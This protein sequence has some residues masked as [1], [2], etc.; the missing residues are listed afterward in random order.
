[1]TR[2]LRWNAHL[3]YA[4]RKGYR[5]VRL[6]VPRRVWLAIVIPVFLLSVGSVGYRWIEG[7]PWTYFDG[8]YMTAITITTIGYGETHPLSNAGRLFTVVLAYSGIF[9]LAYFASE[10][11]RSV[12][13][14]ELR[15]VI[16]RQW[17]DEQLASLGGHLIVCGYGRMGKIV[18]SELE[19]QKRRFVLVERSAEAL[20]DAAY[21]YGLPLVGD[22]TNDELLRKAGVDRAKALVTVVGSDA[23][24]LYITLSA[25]LLNP[26]LLIVARA[27][28]EDA[29]TKLR[30]VGANKVISPYLAGAH[31]AVQAVLRPAVLHFMEMAT[32]P[33]FLDLQIE[34]VRVATGSALAG[35]SLGQ[36]QIHR[37]LGVVVV[38]V[39]RPNGELL[40]NPPS[41]VVIEA[42]AVLIA[43]GQRRHLDRLEKLATCEPG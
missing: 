8:F 43:L 26:K 29:E 30:K 23:D 25:R 35:R 40:Y 19:R 41:D 27:E 6:R 33:E 28:E 2:W 38:G 17:V 14:G 3:R 11:V 20:K 24:N 15:Q 36:S 18:C 9:T 16:G 32:R 42:E 39:V 13:T 22:A 5:W 34:E 37:D 31:R 4:I 10:L 12:V 7:E 1:M 21:Q